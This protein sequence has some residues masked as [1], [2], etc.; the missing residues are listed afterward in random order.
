MLAP[1]IATKNKFTQPLID[2]ILNNNYVESFSSIP[3]NIKEDSNSYVYEFGL[4]GVTKDQINLTAHSSLLNI[5]VSR[6]LSDQGYIHTE[7]SNSMKKMV[8][9]P[10][11]ADVNSIQA[12]F[13][14]GMLYV[15]LTKKN[16]SFSTNSSQIEIE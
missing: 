16:N 7:M 9:L 6:D 14:N 11:N 4:P 3:L 5:E 10:K 8:K 2:S 1:T 13:E 15:T 12:K